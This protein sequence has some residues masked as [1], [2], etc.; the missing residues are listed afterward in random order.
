MGGGGWWWWG[1][2]YGLR[3]RWLL[4]R[5]KSRDSMVRAPS[6]LG[7]KLL[8]LLSFRSRPFCRPVRR[9][10]EGGMDPKR[11]FPARFRTSV[12]PVRPGVGWGG[13][14]WSRV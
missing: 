3:V 11:L 8:R 6:C 7:M 5:R 14:G 2:A 4:S 1:G 9:P 13:V 10:N 12:R